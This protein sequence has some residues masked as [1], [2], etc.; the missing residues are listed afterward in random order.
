MSLGVLAALAA[1]GVYVFDGSGGGGAG[2]GGGGG[3]GGSVTLRGIG[4]Y[5]PPPG[6]GQEHG[7]RARL[8]TDGK[9][10]T[11]WDTETYRSPAFGGLKSGVGLVLDA[12][13]STTLHSVTVSTATPGFTAVI[14]AGDA[15]DGP[16]SDDSQ[17]QTVGAE[18]TFALDGHTARYYVL[19][20]TNLGTVDS[21]HVN[22]IKGS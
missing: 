2:P 21:V 1:G 20:I 18:T 3:G 8:A 13:S 12:G 19:W 4:A 10:S 5:D 6:D 7:A 16:F 9:P 22:E 14:R 17:S 11:F 15:P